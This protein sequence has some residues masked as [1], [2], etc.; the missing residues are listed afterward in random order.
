MQTTREI[1]GT[2]TERGILRKLSDV[3]KRNKV[4]T[5]KSVEKVTGTYIQTIMRPIHA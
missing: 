3:Q 2:R 1:R 4:K 5:G